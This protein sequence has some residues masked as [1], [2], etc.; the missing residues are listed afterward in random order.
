MQPDTELRKSTYQAARLHAS[1]SLFHGLPKGNAQG[2]SDKGTRVAFNSENAREM[3]ER[4]LEARRKNAELR[5]TVTADV[6]ARE[7]LASHAEALA[8]ELLSAA[9]GK[10]DYAGHLKPK[11]R[12]QAVIKALEWGIGRPIPATQPEEQPAENEEIPG[13]SFT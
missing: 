13:I 8:K 1:S 12:L 2:G 6:R 10:G 9:L 11:E 3:A 4:A 5:A 7:V